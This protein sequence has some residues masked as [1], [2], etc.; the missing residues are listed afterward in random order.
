M[1]EVMK[2]MPEQAVMEMC[3]IEAKITGQARDPMEVLANMA[4]EAGCKSVPEAAP[5]AKSGFEVVWGLAH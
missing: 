1:E 5:R 2:D 3:M 4:A